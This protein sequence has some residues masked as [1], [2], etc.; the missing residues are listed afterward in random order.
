MKRFE[1]FGFDTVLNRSGTNSYKWDNAEVL[2]ENLLPLSV[3]DMDFATPAVVT[4]ALVNRTTQPVYG[5]EFQPDA[6]KEAIIEWNDKRHGF[7]VRQ[8]WLLFT[9][10]VV[11]GL[12]ISILSFTEKGD[13]IVIQPPVYPAFFSVVA[14]NDRQLI[15]N[16]LNYDADSL[17]YT[18]DFDSL[19]KIFF[20]QNPRLMFLCNP[21]NPIGRV[22]TRD[23]LR[24]LGELCQKYQVILI[25]DDIHADLTFAGHR[26]H[27]L[28]SLSETTENKAIQLMSPG[29]AFNIPGLHFSYAVVANRDLRDRFSEK[30]SALALANTNIM[31]AVAAQ[32]VYQ[33]GTQ[34]LDSVLEYIWNNYVFLKTTLSGEL[35]WAKVIPLEGTFLAWIDLSASGLNPNQLSHVVRKRAKLMLFEGHAFGDAGQGFMRINLACPQET[36]HKAVKQLVKALNQ[37]KESPPRSIEIMD[38][39]LPT[40][41]CCN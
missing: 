9:P 6:L 36:L 22:W 12:A 2:N 16:P 17:K 27:P 5:Y 29:K 32:A 38:K 8:E 41:R 11:T 10:G 14:E 30:L 24:V 34:W 33:N 13:R 19:E 3:A 40:C 7:E 1:Q 21:H 26:Y 18:M 28:I 31:A 35:S 39:P 15:L 4:Q 23:E 25:S 20:E 37:A